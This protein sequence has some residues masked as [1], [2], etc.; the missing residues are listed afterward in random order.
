MQDQ[1]DS[2]YLT[3][4]VRQIVAG[5]FVTLAAVVVL[6][7]FVWV[8]WRFVLKQPTPSV[9]RIP[10]IEV[11]FSASMDFGRD[12]TTKHVD[13]VTVHVLMCVPYFAV[14]LWLSIHAGKARSSRR[15]AYLSACSSNVGRA[16]N[17]AFTVD[18]HTATHADGGKA[19]RTW[20]RAEHERVI[21]CFV[22]RH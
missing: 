15:L 8:V 1:Q 13:S 19:N 12:S 4:N 5:A 11:L 21:K 17:T 18:T 6:H 10:C 16:F 2:P 7:T 9:L 22:R 14:L 3:G 20:P